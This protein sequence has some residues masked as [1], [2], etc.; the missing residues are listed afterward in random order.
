M[1]VIGILC[2]REDTVQEI[3]VIERGLDQL[4]YAVHLE[5]MRTDAV[6]LD[7]GEY[8]YEKE[9]IVLWLCR[10][11]GDIGRCTQAAEA[12]VSAGVDAIVAMTETALQVALPAAEETKTPIVFTHITHEASTEKTIERLRRADRLTGVWDLWLELAQDRLALITELVPP[13]TTVHVFCNPELPTATAEA[14]ALKRAGERLSI[15]VIVH[16]A[17]TVPEAK[18]RVAALN[19]H[20]DHAL[21]RLADPT[22]DSAAGLMGAVAHEQNIPYIGLTLS[23]LE[24]NGALFAVETRGA[25]IRVAQ[26]IHR[27]LGGEAPSSISCNWPAEKVIGVNLQGAQDLGLILSPAVMAKA[28]IVLPAQETRR[29][30]TQ[31]LGVLVLALFAV[32]IIVALTSQ[33]EWAYMPVLAAAMSVA[34]VVWMWVYLNRRVITPIRELAITAE[35]IGAGELNSP[36]ADSKASTEV[37]LLAR[38]LRRMRSNL[39]TSYADMAQLNQELKAE[40]AELT[41]A[42]R[43]LE[44]TKQKLE[45]AG[46]RIVEAEDS[47]RFAL[48]TFIH[49]EVYRPMD[50][51]NAIAEELKDPAL[52]GLSR[53]LEQHIRQIRFELSVPILH[54]IGIELRRL[55]QEILPG[56]Y[57]D[58][59]AVKTTLDVACLDR[60]LQL[61]SAYTFLIYRFVRGALSNAYR[62]SGATQV[63]VSAAIEHSSLIL[64]VSDNGVGFDSQAIER[65]IESGHYFFYDVETRARQLKGELAVDSSRGQ[66]TELRVVLPLPGHIRRTRGPLTAPRR[67]TPEKSHPESEPL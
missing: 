51:I 3:P 53:E 6:S 21:L 8:Y 63:A 62:H 37:N 46:R 59:R 18:E 22:F 7:P 49:D 12:F 26:M 67:R 15:K 43:D 55:T 35:K 39:K 38:A 16:E 34:L 40:V 1:Y 9:S 58:A 11:Y 47:G 20:Q 2:L 29:L 54:D 41:E 50:E 57:P 45:L 27:I 30:A 56:M 25:G 65:F 32:N 17:H 10:C 14:D 13:P 52:L 44:L 5:Q 66:G 31:F 4:G 24:R 23:E 36:I 42:N 60:N 48:T 28:Q 61:G 19:A 33:L 64:R